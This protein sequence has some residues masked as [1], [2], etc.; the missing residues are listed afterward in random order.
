MR[1]AERA[2]DL[3]LEAEL[4]GDVRGAES[5]LLEVI[6]EAKA[7]EEAAPK[8]RLEAFVRSLSVRRAAFERHGRSARA[9]AVA[10]DSM[11]PFGLERAERLWAK[12]V[13]DVPA[14]GK[15]PLP[16]VAV[17]LDLVKGVD[18]KAVIDQL[19]RAMK[20]YGFELADQKNARFVVRVNLDATDVKRDPRGVRVS[21]EATAVVSDRTQPKRAAGSVS[22]LR[23]ER[24]T[25]E[26]DARRFALYRVLDDV[27]RR[28][29]FAVHQRM[30]EDA[31]PP[32]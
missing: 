4:A 21:A 26:D 8:Q 31:A 3:G 24:R 7:A 23:S 14:I 18:Q 29:V 32:T 15:A 6:A 20:K 1:S 2:I 16:R 5:S 12:A 27:G 10:Y 22:K 9:Y 19:E 30:L 25:E 17:R 13:A 28:V 11:L